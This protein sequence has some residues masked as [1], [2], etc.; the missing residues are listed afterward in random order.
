MSSRPPGRGG[1]SR[2]RR[3]PYE[4]VLRRRDWTFPP[5][6]LRHRE[7]VSVVPDDP[8]PGR[9]PL[10]F[11]HG[12][13]MGAWAWERW[14]PAAAEAGWSAHAVSLRGHGRS[15][16]PSPLARTPLRYYEHDVLQAITELPAA[17]VLVGHSLGALVV[18][19]VLER[20]R[21]A[22]AGVLVCPAPP[23]HG[24]EVFGAFLANDP[25]ALAAVFAGRQPRPKAASLF[26]PHTDPARAQAYAVRMG[27]ESMLV[28]LQV[29]APRRTRDV[30]TP[31]LVI[32][33]GEDRMVPPHA[34]TRTA[35]TFGTRAHLF[36]GLGHLLMLEDRAQAPLEFILAWLQ[37][38]L[39]EP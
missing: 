19:H 3:H 4:P 35:R 39:R 25:G 13:A 1:G 20:Y 15:D 37:S 34:V 17:P 7:I 5:P 21:A 9:P 12:A 6:A 26:G 38:T 14:L 36:R 32:G 16:A 2:S 33:G 11:V 22:P 18:Q 30:R 24:V 31:L 8:V 29:V 27:H 28:P 10:L 23:R